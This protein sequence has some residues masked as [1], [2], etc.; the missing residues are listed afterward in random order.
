MYHMYGVDVTCPP[1][2]VH[3]TSSV[4]SAVPSFSMTR[5][6]SLTIRYAASKRGLSDQDAVDAELPFGFWNRTLI[7]LMDPSGSRTYS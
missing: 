1:S 4:L 3:L 5:S 2:D 7:M 6:C